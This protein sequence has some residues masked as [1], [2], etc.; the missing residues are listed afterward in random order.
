[1][2]LNISAN[3]RPM[4]DPRVQLAWNWRKLPMHWRWLDTSFFDQ[5][6][7]R[8]AVEAAKSDKERAKK[9]AEKEGT[10]AGNGQ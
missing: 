4:D 6:R 1:M 7:A 2:A 3:N 5:V 9:I 8:A 10:R